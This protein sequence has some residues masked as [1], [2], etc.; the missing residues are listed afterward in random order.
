MMANGYSYIV[1]ICFLCQNEKHA[2]RSCKRIDFSKSQCC[3]TCGFP[4]RFF[5][6][7]IHGDMRTGECEL[8]FRDLMKGLCWRVYRVAELREKY[9]SGVKNIEKELDYKGWLSLMDTSGEMVNG[10]RLML[11]VWRS[12]LEE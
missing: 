8:G 12:R 2:M 10:C 9:L 3:V 11:N 4:Q 7:K 5:D 6:E 1:G